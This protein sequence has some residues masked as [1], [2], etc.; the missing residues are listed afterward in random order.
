MKKV[1]LNNGLEMP[2]LGIG[3]YALKSDEAEFAVKIALQNGYRLIDT[4]NVYMNEKAVGRGIKASGVKREDIFISSKLWPQDYAYEKAKIAIDKTL[5]RLGVD[6]ID[7]LLLHQQYGPYLEAWKAMEEAVKEGKVRSIGL[8]DFNAKRFQDVIDHA[9]ILPVLHQ[10]ETHP[11]YQER[12][13]AS[14]ATKTNTYIESWFPLGGREDISKILNNKVL[15]EIAK[16]HN[17]TVAQVVIRW[18]LQ[19]GYIVIPGS[20]N[21]EHIKENI[22]VFNF[23][24]TENDMER[25]QKLD[26]NG[27]FFTLSEE[28]QEKWFMGSTLDFDN[29]K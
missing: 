28:E 3:V 27:R 15:V 7:L 25:I 19:M 9:K 29:Q 21:E 24:L 23:E 4:A 17:K 12:D 8:S 1:R 13:L 22:N 2:Q 16:E 20:S 26:G 10:I 14:L 5:E 11:F 18:H 6:Y